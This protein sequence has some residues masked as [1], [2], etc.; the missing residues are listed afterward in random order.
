MANRKLKSY[1]REQTIGE[2]IANAV[3]HG[4]GT[5]FAITAL[6]LLVTYASISGNVWRIVTLSIFGGSLILLY[7]FS[8]LY[9]SATHPKLKQVFHVFDH[10]AIYLVI[11]GSYTP[12]MLGPLRGPWGWALFGIIWGIAFVGIALKVF[13]VKCMP[14]LSLGTYIAMGWLIVIAFK[15]MMT[16]LPYGLIFWLGVG[17][18][19]YMIGTLFYTWERLPYHHAIWHS[20]VLGGSFFHFWGMFHYL[21]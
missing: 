1:T 3:V 19:S 18:L 16:H 17:G 6:C 9:H 8:T 21:T 12:I 14:W 2:E 10:V 20:F 15:P 11:A 13:R 7:L 4:I 5:L